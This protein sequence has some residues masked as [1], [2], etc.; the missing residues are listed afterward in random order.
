MNNTRFATALHILTLLALKPEEWLSSEFIATSI[1]VNA[2]IVR[3][4]LITL[5]ASGLI[6]TKKG[7]EGGAKLSR[8]ANEIYL[9]EVFDSIN[10]SEILGRKN[11]NTNQKCP[12]GKQINEKL[13]VLFERIDRVVKDDLEQ[14]N[15]EEFLNQF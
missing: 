8:R 15:L 13:D 11:L 3:K 10:T 14:Q 5:A 4:E 1:N 9:S 6:L 7:K 12:I 2:V